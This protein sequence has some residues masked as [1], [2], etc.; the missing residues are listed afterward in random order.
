MLRKILKLEH[1]LNRYARFV[2]VM[3][4]LIASVLL[5]AAIVLSC[6]DES[7]SLYALHGEFARV[8]MFV[9]AEGIIAGLLFDVICTRREQ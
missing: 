9:F 6:L 5:I 4:L 1:K 2:M 8:G 7:S 3:G